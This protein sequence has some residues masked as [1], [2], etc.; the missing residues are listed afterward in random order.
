[1]IP[2]ARRFAADANITDRV[3]VMPLDIVREV[4]TG[5]FDV[6]VV[7][8]FLQILSADEAQ[9]ALQNISKAK[10]KNLHIVVTT[11]LAA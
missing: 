4:P 6:V 1:M 8:A 2:I 5:S 7:K 3:E 11:T 9:S 10:I